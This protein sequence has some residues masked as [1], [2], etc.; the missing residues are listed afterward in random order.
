ML[1]SRLGPA[2]AASFA[3]WNASDKGA[4]MFLTNLDLTAEGRDGT[5]SNVRGTLGKSSGAWYWEMTIN[6]RPNGMAIGVATAAAAIADGSIY[7][8]ST[9]GWSYAGD[10]NKYTNGA[11]AAYGAVYTTNN[12]I[13]VA[14][15]MSSGKLWF[16]INGVWQNS[17][18]PAAGTGEAFSGI[19]GTIYPAFGGAANGTDYVRVT[20]RTG[21]LHAPPSGFLPLNA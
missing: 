1:T 12:V 4:S 14:L 11:G 7:W 5:Y 8:S 18:D 15:N 16:S 3:P 21:L 20:M 13:G 2:V 10:G 6:N 17:G 9:T 19:S